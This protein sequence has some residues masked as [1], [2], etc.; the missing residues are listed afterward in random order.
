MSAPPPIKYPPLT[1][2]TCSCSRSLWET[3][4]KALWFPSTRYFSLARVR[5]RAGVRASDGSTGNGGWPPSQP[6]PRGGRSKTP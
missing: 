4:A 3:A 2:A 1:G 5:E 6:S